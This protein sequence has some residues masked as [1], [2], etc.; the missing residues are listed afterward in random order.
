MARELWLMDQ[1]IAFVDII[2]PLWFSM[3]M[4]HLGYEQWVRWW[5]QFIDVVS[6]HLIDMIM[7]NIIFNGAVSKIGV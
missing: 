6:P 2:I 7:I 4:Y 1:E 5:P 3:L